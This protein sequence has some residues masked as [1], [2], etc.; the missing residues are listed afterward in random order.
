[1]THVKK[2]KTCQ[3]AP[4]GGVDTWIKLALREFPETQR[5]IILVNNAP[6]TNKKYDHEKYVKMAY[7]SSK[8]SFM[9]SSKS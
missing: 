7:Y 6:E 3:V 2:E 8:K 1:M 5:L 9:R 4:Y